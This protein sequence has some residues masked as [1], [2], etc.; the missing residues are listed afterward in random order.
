[1]IADVLTIGEAMAALYSDHPLRLGGELRLS[2][3][4]AETNV[5]IGLARLGHRVRWSGRVGDDELGALVQRTLRAEQVDITDAVVAPGEPTGMLLFDRAP[6]GATRVH[7]RRAGSAASRL[8]PEDISP[9]MAHGA[10]VLHVTGIT[11]ALG[12]SPAAAIRYAIAQA[13]ATGTSVCLD[14]NYRSTLW[15]AEQ[16]TPVLRELSTGVDVLVASEE[17]LPLAAEGDGEASQVTALLAAGVREVVVKRGGRGASAYT[18]QGRHDISARAVDVVN[19]VGAGD[20]FTAGYLSALLDGAPV[21]QRLDRGAAL[22]AAAVASTGD[23]EGLPSRA[24]LHGV[25]RPTQEA[26]R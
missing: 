12:A 16:A 9:A 23:W 10:R 20:A 2:V 5:A 3:A 17:E 15:P 6:G 26:L 18:R 22:G 11:P 7:Y 14:V 8:T 13:R 25:G 19:T 24:E 1:M 4:G 21:A